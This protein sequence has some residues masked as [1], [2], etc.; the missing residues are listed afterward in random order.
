MEYMKVMSASEARRVEEILKEK[1]RQGWKV[2]QKE[3]EGEEESELEKLVK[4]WM[5]ELI[6]LTIA[7]PG[8]VTEGMLALRMCIQRIRVGENLSAEEELLLR[9]ALV[10]VHGQQKR[11][12]V[13][14]EDHED[15]MN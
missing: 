12:D 15:E 5:D 2:M 13:G 1:E 8:K 4:E 3:E 10:K 9:D 7:T 11:V 14:M 6:E